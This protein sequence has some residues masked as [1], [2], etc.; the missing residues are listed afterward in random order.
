[1]SAG[2][3]AANGTMMRTGWFGYPCADACVHSPTASA[4]MQRTGTGLSM[5][6]PP[7][8]RRTRAPFVLFDCPGFDRRSARQIAMHAADPLD[9]ALGGEALV[10]SLDTESAQLLAPRRQPL[11]PALQPPVRRLG[12]VTRE[13]G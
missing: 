13:V 2:P 1:M 9:L 4:I 8:D 3:P 11:F 6:V 7:D 12:I 5:D 10:E